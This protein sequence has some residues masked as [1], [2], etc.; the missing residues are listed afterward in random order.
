MPFKV[1]ITASAQP[2]IAPKNP[3]QNDNTNIMLKLYR[4]VCLDHAFRFFN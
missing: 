4:K 1:H 2:T 3:P